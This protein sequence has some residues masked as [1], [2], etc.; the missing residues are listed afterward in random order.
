MAHRTSNVTRNRRTVEFLDVRPSHRVLEIGFG[1]GLSI[2]DAAQ[3]AYAGHVTGIDHSSAMVRAATKRNQ[4]AIR[5]GRVELITENAASLTSG[6]FD[7]IFA[8]NVVQFWPD[9]RETLSSLRRRLRPGGRIALT[10]Q[11]RKRG[12]T[13]EQARAYG[14]SVGGWLWDAGFA[15]IQIE[16][17][18]VSP[19]AV[20]VLAEPN[21]PTVA[22]P[23]EV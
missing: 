7:R 10:F 17:I 12:A 3:R 21:T 16:E 18:E 2:A 22:S 11:P 8:V 19:I 9:P 1:P 6:K 20:C 4:A 23:S 15:N 5:V 13:N 14:D